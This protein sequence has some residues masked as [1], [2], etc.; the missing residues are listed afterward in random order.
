MLLSMFPS[1]YRN[2]DLVSSQNA[3]LKK[4][5]GLIWHEMHIRHDMAWNNAY[6]MYYGMENVDWYIICRK[7][8][9]KDEIKTLKT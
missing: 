4:R 2:T 8:D 7:I 6:L 9:R 3:V 5:L 1:S